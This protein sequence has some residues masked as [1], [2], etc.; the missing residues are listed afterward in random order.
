MLEN[1]I[2]SRKFLQKPNENTPQKEKKMR[3]EWDEM[4]YRFVG[5]ASL[6]SN[7]K[8]RNSMTS[9]KWIK[10]PQNFVG[11]CLHKTNKNM[12]VNINKQINK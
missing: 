7:S 4:L 5:I 9:W 11:C 3:K 8:R 6:T 2:E 10:K 12:Q 1:F